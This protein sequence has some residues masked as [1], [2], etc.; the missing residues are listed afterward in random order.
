MAKSDQ[1][2]YIVCGPLMLQSFETTDPPPMGHCGGLTKFSGDLM[3][4]NNMLCPG[5]RWN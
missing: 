4:F 3:Q 5:G 1:S 2:I